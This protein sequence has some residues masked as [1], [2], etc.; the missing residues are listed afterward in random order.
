MQKKC[1]FHTR[2][3]FSFVFT[4]SVAESAHPRRLSRFTDSIFTP[5]FPYVTLKVV[6]PFCDRFSR[7]KYSSS[8]HR[9]L[10]KSLSLFGPLSSRK[11]FLLKWNIRGGVLQESGNLCCHRSKVFP[12]FLIFNDIFVTFSFFFSLN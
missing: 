1:F 4:L 6:Q 10:L 11:Y 9:H 7:K 2:Q 5:L 8:M 3:R 12:C